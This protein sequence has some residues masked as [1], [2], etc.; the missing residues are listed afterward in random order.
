MTM[1]ESLTELEVEIY[2]QAYSRGQADAKADFLS[3]IDAVV[4]LYPAFTYSMIEALKKI[5]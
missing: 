2:K 4:K 3:H 1:T 5:P